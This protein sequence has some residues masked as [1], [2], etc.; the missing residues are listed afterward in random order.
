MEQVFQRYH[1]RAQ[2]HQFNFG[3]PTYCPPLGVQRECEALLVSILE[4]MVAAWN[5]LLS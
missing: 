3:I 1:D 2:R 4:N 5:E